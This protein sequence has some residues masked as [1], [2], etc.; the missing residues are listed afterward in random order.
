MAKKTWVHDGTMFRDIKRIYVNDD[1]TWKLM[2]RAYIYIT[3]MGSVVAKQIYQRATILTIASNTSN[4]NIAT[5]CGCCWWRS[6]H[7]SNP[8]D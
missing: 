4:F 5:S 1:G 3:E 2:S 6:K 8:N 7:P